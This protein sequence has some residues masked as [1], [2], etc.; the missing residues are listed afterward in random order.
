[1]PHDPAAAEGVREEGGQHREHANALQ[2]SPEKAGGSRDEEHDDGPSDGLRVACETSGG[3]T[4]GVGGEGF[5][6]KR[7]ELRWMMRRYT[8]RMMLLTLKSMQALG[9]KRRRREGRGERI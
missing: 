2:A 8:C 9:V 6:G 4:E 7:R 1:M 3:A 5:I